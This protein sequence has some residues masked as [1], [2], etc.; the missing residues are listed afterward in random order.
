MKKVIP[1]T[2]LF[3]LTSITKAQL[4]QQ[5]FAN[6][7]AS[8]TNSALV[9]ANYINI[10]TPTS[11]QFTYLA[12][13]H[14]SATLSVPDATDDATNPFALKTVTT[15]TSSIWAVGRNVN[16]ATNPTAVKISFDLNVIPGSSGSNPKWFFYLGNGFTNSVTTEANANIHSGFAMRYTSSTYFLRT[17]SGTES[18]SF[19]GSTNRSV[20]FVVN[21]S[22][23]ALTYPDPNGATETI[24]NDSWDLWVGTTKVFDDQAAT[25]ATQ[26][27]NN[28]KFGDLVSSSSGRA[29]MYIDNF[30]ITNLVVTT[31][32]SFAKVMAFQKGNGIQVDFTTS[33]EL[34]VERYIIEKS[35]DGILF[36]PT[37]NLASKGNSNSLTNYSFYDDNLITGSYFYRIKALEK[38]GTTKLSNILKVGINKQKSNIAIAPNPIK[39]GVVNIQINNLIKSTYAIKVINNL[40]QIIVTKSLNHEGGSGAFYL[41]L[42]TTTKK[43]VYRLLIQ[44]NKTNFQK[45]LNIE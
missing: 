22:G 29:S 17:L 18:T 26:D 1:F 23:G 2:F 21:N 40:G 14:S 37:G 43:G 7:V 13:G 19:T 24:A 45:Q 25:T 15:S 12:S 28:F 27:L 10:L 6:R 5:Q 20:V 30:S 42:P 38:D 32:I 34:N 8:F 9:D 36:F 33:F 35:T 4:F 44:S 31:P 41:N 11:N 3:L 16:F 39:N